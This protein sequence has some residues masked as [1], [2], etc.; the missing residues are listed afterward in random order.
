MNHEHHFQ[1]ILVQTQA[2]LG[3]NHPGIAPLIFFLPHLWFDYYEQTPLQ[4]IG[5][6]AGGAVYPQDK[7][8]DRPNS[9]IED[10]QPKGVRIPSGV[11]ENK[12]FSL[13]TACSI[14]KRNSQLCCGY[15]V[16][17]LLKG[18]G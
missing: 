8:Q 7:T 4:C 17:S 9:T 1:P 14:Q 18:L 16:S 15:Q 11:L 10:A 5:T 3:G 2:T 13:F 6:R 12:Y